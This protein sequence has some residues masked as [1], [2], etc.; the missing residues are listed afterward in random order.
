MEKIQRT[1]TCIFTLT[2]GLS[3]IG[4]IVLVLAQ[5]VALAAGQGALLTGLSDALKAPVCIAASLCAIAGFL[6][7]YQV[8]NTTPNKHRAAH[9]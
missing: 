7:S 3:L 8:R 2:L 1:I 5:A 4:G 9:K 6:L